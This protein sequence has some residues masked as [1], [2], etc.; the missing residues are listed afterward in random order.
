MK[1][2]RPLAVLPCRM[3]RRPCT[4]WSS[5][6]GTAVGSSKIASST[7]YCS[8]SC[9]SQSLSSTSCGNHTSAILTTLRFV[10]HQ[11]KG[12]PTGLVRTGSAQHQEP[13]VLGG[14]ERSR[15]VSETRRSQ[16]VHRYDAGR[17]SS[18]GQGLNPWVLAAGPWWAETRS[19]R[20]GPSRVISLAPVA[21]DQDAR[22]VIAG[23]I[24]G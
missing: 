15:A 16:A 7:S 9:L 8:S 2:L 14:H 12:C 3:T 1:R 23:S 20:S 18:T 22:G 5:H 17:Q 19:S 10:L 24:V 11:V 13:L 6:T 21:D 4:R